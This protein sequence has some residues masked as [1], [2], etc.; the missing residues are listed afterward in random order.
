MEINYVCSLGPR[1]HSTEILKRNN[2]KKVSF[3]FDWLFSSTDNV[4]HCIEDDFKIFLDR[5]YYIDI[6]EKQCGHS[7]YHPQ[8]FY[9][10]NPLCNED[11]YNYYLRCVDRFKKLLSYEERKLFVMIFINKSSIGQMNRDG[12]VDF[13][14]KLSKYTKNY[15]L[16]IIYHICDKEKNDHNFTYNDNIHFLELHTLSKSN[17]VKFINVEDNNYLNDII[18]KSYNFNIK[19]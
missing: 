12:V 9:H 18:I 14:N 3:P 2:L 16:L 8:M 15:I 19:N 10:H 4:L 13:N 11:D 5:S 7:Y 6:S 17:G 1:C